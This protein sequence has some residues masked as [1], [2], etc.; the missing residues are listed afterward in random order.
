MALFRGA[1]QPV[2]CFFLC[3]VLRDLSGVHATQIVLC[4]RVALFGRHSPPVLCL[5]RVDRDSLPCQVD[6]PEH[7]LSARMMSLRSQPIPALGLLETLLD[8][9]SLQIEDR[10]VVAAVGVALLRGRSTPAQR[11]VVALNDPVPSRIEISELCLC[12]RIALLARQSV[13]LDCLSGITWCLE[14]FVIDDGQA[15]LRDL[16]TAVGSL[17]VETQCGFWIG[18][19]AKTFFVRLGQPMKRS[20]MTQICGPAPEGY[21]LHRIGRDAFTPMRQVA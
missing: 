7:I 8:A 5:F 12:R 3:D 2:E 15:I 20:C 1:S 4:G 10:E 16:I 19:D 17:A 6:C 14:S 13:V 21:G 9:E 11:F 18:I